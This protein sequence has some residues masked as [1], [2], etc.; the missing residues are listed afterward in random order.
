MIS[1]LRLKKH[2][3][4]GKFFLS[5][6]ANKVKEGA[7]A[8]DEDE[9]EVK[10]RRINIFILS[11]PEIMIFIVYTRFAFSLSSQYPKNGNFFPLLCISSTF[12]YL[13]VIVSYDMKEA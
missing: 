11:T 13:I 5:N 6:V 1:Q 3:T 2:G 8:E 9:E 12:V 10:R 4:N 7:Q